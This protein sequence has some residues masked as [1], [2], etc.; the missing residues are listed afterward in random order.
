MKQNFLLSIL[1]LLICLPSMAQTRKIDGI[2]YEVIAG[3]NT[4]RVKDGGKAKGAIT[5]PETIEIKGKEYTV[6]EIGKSAFHQ[7]FA[8]KKLETITLPKTIRRIEATAFYHTNLK[9]IQLPEGVTYIGDQAFNNCRFLSAIHLPSGIA[10]IGTAAFF[11]CVSLRAVDIPSGIKRIGEFAFSRCYSLSAVKIPAGI[12]EIGAGAFED[13]RSLKAVMLP[14]R[15]T[16]TLP[17]LTYKIYGKSVDYGRYYSAGKCI[18]SGCTQISYVRGYTNPY[19]VYAY[20]WLPKDCPFIKEGLPLLNNSFSFFAYNKFYDRMNQ[21]RQKGEYETTAQWRSRVTAESQKKQADDVLADL[22]RKFISQHA[23]R[24]PKGTLGAYNADQSAYPVNIEGATTFY[25]QVPVS[26]A[27]AF[28]ANWT[29]VQMTPEYGIV[30]D[31]LAVLSCTFTLDGKTYQS[32]NNL[33]NDASTQFAANLPP[34]EAD[35]SSVQDA[36][37][38]VASVP[39]A[40]DTAIDRDIPVTTAKN[41]HTFAVVISNEAYQHVVSVPYAQNDAAIFAAY[42]EKTLGLPAANIRRYRN[43]TYGT[44]L[45]ALAD[46]RDIA[47]AFKGDID[48]LFYYAGHGIPSENG[49]DA[50]LLPVDADGTQPEVCLPLSRLYRELGELQARSTVVFLDACFSGSQR[51]EG[52]LASARGVAIKADAGRPQGNVVA[53]SAATGEETA[54][55]YAEKGHGMF[56]YFLLKKLHDTKGD[57]TLGELADYITEEVKKT[58]VVNNRKKQ[59]PTVIPAPG[60]TSWRELK[61]Q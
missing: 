24:L 40:T 9:S 4:A 6:V 8:T 26:E 58:S 16:F 7:Y 36:A 28:K 18:F 42:C 39:A 49:R 35:F 27:P 57:V 22:R 30:D 53:F 60:I 44:L 34:L 12:K 50:Y 10:E 37:P 56:T 33:V 25:A 38:V 19:P 15:E 17:N 45:S 61:L 48:I 43:A 46:L 2:F 11:E 1:C 31:R 13:C 3:T 14:D 54:Y 21:W 29:R 55:P 51:G 41:D 59:T 52:M 47:E 23:P 32:A 20:D 5:I